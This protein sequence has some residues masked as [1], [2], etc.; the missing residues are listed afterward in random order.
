MNIKD[1]AMKEKLVDTYP[2][3]VGVFENQRIILNMKHFT[4]NH[5]LFE[6]K[7]SQFWN[8]NWEFM[9][10]VITN[11]TYQGAMILYFDPAPSP[12]YYANVFRKTVNLRDKFQFGHFMFTA[13]KQEQ[14]NFT[15]PN[16]YPFNYVLAA[17]NNSYYTN[18]P[19]GIVYMDTVSALQTT[20]PV[21]ILNILISE[22]L[23]DVNHY[24]NKVLTSK[25]Q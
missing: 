2:W 12:N 7:I 20:S 19:L 15:T 16:L 11:G 8:F 22:R 6:N 1:F 13:D 23:I 9:Y 3:R 4:N 14:I 10:K 5:L 25:F 21:K 24:G 18:Y 17:S